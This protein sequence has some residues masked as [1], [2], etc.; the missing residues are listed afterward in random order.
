LA[1][2]PNGVALAVRPPAGPISGDI[3][4]LDNTNAFRR[5]LDRVDQRCEHLL[6][7]HQTELPL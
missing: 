7:R 5:I 3:G 1:I 4:N 6:E 2:E